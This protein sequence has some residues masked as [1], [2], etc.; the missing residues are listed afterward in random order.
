MRAQ[1]TSNSKMATNMAASFRCSRKFSQLCRPVVADRT[2]NFV[3]KR[4]LA[5]YTSSAFSCLR[6]ERG[7]L[8]VFSISFGKDRTALVSTQENRFSSSATTDDAPQLSEWYYSLILLVVV[9]RTWELWRNNVC[10]LPPPPPHYN[11]HHPLPPPKHTPPLRFILFIRPV[12]NTLCQAENLDDLSGSTD[13]SYCKY[14][15]LLRLH[16]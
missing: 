3:S 8:P 4:C 6:S 1:K 16:S 7:R 14:K 5:R 9:E 11:N 10:T 15:E 13:G 12:S 2:L